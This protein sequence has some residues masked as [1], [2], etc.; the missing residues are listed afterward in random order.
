M[1]ERPLSLNIRKGVHVQHHS[2]LENLVQSKIN[3]PSLIPIVDDIIKMEKACLEANKLIR[4][5][6][7]CLKNEYCISNA[8]IL[9]SILRMQDDFPS[10]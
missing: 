8:I 9:L 7:G 5:D 3:L 6:L 10:S 1:K 2:F 4:N